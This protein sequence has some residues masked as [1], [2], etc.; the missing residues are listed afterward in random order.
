VQEAIA[1][2]MGQPPPGQE[3]GVT[4]TGQQFGPAQGEYH[5]TKRWAMTVSNATTREIVDNPPAADRQRKPGE[6][7]FLRPSARRGSESLAALL[8]IYHSIPL[9]RE[10]LLL[11]NYQQSNYGYDPQWWTGQ[12]IETSRTVSFHDH[13]AQYHLDDII[14]EMQRLMAFLDGTT[15]AYASVDALADLQNHVKKDADSYLSRFLDAWSHGAMIRSR[16]DPLTQVFSSHGIRSDPGNVM[17]KDFCCL[18]AMVDPD[19]EPS[20]VDILDNVIWSDPSMGGPLHD[21]WLDRIGEIMTLKLADP[22]KKQGKLDVEIPTVW[23]PDRYMEHFRELSHD[24]RVRRWCTQTEIRRLEHSR[25]GILTCPVIGRQE[26]L[27]IKKVLLDAAERAPVVIKNQLSQATV[28]PAMSSA[29]LSSED[30]NECVKGLQGLVARIELKAAQIESIK[31]ELTAHC[32]AITAELT[33]PSAEPSISPYHRYTL[34]GVSTKEHIVYLLRPTVEVMPY[35]EHN[36]S[37]SRPWQWW[38]ISLSN[39][40]AEAKQKPP[41]VYGPS[42]RPLP[43]SKATDSIGASIP[44]STW[45]TSERDGNLVAYAIRKVSEEEVLRAA[46]VEGDSVTLVYASDKAVNYQGSAL[47]RPL[48]LFVNADNKVFD[49]ELRG[50]EQSQEPDGATDG[51]EMAQLHFSNLDG[52]QD[53]PLIDSSDET[54]NEE[55]NGVKPT[56]NNL[57]ARRGADGQPSPKRA[58]AD[59][60]PPPYPDNERPTPEMQERSGGM[61]ILRKVQSNHTENR[62]DEPINT[63]KDDAGLDSTGGKYLE[64]PRSR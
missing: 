47:S 26:N 5:D 17:Q 30:V 38:R 45:P 50:I 3:N 35:S 32:K 63:A 44:Y 16:D 25:T 9:A 49:S 48:Q 62:G 43:N 10:A 52:M 15:R 14:I 4:G 8:T 12:H 23:Y 24:M 37:N 6:P 40:E 20:F 64:R 46:R 33:M 22:K 60:D 29:A 31:E 51:E 58:K 21:V 42:P 2:S 19:I 55:K 7:A 11:P 18:E 36:G 41:V 34:R 27:D 54:L 59:D 61:G 56:S 13:G 1:L 28:G 57:P 53:I 39:E